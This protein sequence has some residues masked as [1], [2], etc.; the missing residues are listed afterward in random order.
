[1]KMLMLLLSLL[2]AGAAQAQMKV[3]TGGEKGTYHK[4]F[5]NLS[6]TCGP[7]EEEMPL[8]SGSREN[9]D[10]LLA[11][12]A[13]LA[14]VQSDVLFMIDNEERKIDNLKTLYALHNEEVHVVTPVQTRFKKSE[15]A[16]LKKVDIAFNSVGD[17]V[18]QP[19]GAVGGSARTIEFI[20]KRANLNL[21]VKEFGNNDELR[22]AMEK[23][24][25]A[26]GIYVGGQPLE[27]VTVLGPSFKLIPFPDVLING[28]SKW[29][30]PAKLSYAKLGARGV[31]T[32]A[33]EAVLVA[34]VLSNP[35]RVKQ[36]ALLRTCITQHL[37]DLQDNGHPKWADV[38]A[39]NHGRWTWYELPSVASEPAKTSDK[40][41][42]S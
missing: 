14:F 15:Y 40:K 20:S 31:P 12:K 29:Y 4:M 18:G 36:Y 8:S 25:I 9:V 19:V 28:L 1:M 27:S 30:G 33:A 3:K 13:Y 41:K 26:A 35:E 24:E 5:L 22:G 42:K 11:N 7:L 32:V 37:G 38:K 10:D 39:E 2:L 17:L 23:G 21:Q 6:E 34:R 16:G